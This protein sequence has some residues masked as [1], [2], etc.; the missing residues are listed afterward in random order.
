MEHSTLMRVEWSCLHGWQ[1]VK[2][3]LNRV[4]PEDFSA[5][6]SNHMHNPALWARHGLTFP[7]FS[8]KNQL[9]QTC[10]RADSHASLLSST[11]SG[12]FLKA[13]Q[14]EWRSTLD[15]VVY[16]F[17]GE[18]FSVAPRP[19]DSQITPQPIQRG[20]KLPGFATFWDTGVDLVSKAL[21]Q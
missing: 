21:A 8:F 14:S 9:T 18:R 16:G 7:C 3:G 11:K 15:W 12:T 10:S 5:S 20:N 2:F 13:K 1:F 19:H 17:V 4:Q 6:P